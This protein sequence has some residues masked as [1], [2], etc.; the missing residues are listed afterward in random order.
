MATAA[1]ALVAS[2]LRRAR[3]LPHLG[4]AELRANAVNSSSFSS[5]TPQAPPGHDVR[6]LSSSS[7]SQALEST[8]ELDTQST[9]R[10]IG[11]SAH[12]DSGKTTLTERILF[13]SGRISQIHEV[14]GKDGVGAKMDSMELEREKG[15]TIQSAATYCSWG[16]NQINIIDT[17]GHVDFTVEVERALRVLDGAVLVL[18]SVGGVQ[19]QSITVDRQMKRYGVPRL[20][21]VNKLDR[22]GANPDKVMAQ[23]REKLR[24]NCAAVQ[25]P[26][27]LEDQHEGVVDLVNLR[28]Y[29]FEGDMGTEVAE[30]SEIPAHLAD[31][32]RERRAELVEALAEVDD[33]IGE[34]FLED[35]EPSEE[36]LKAAIRRQTIANAFVPVFMGSAYKNKGVQRLLDGVV[37]YLPAPNEVKNMALDVSREGEEKPVELCSRD[38]SLPLVAMAFKLEEGRFGQLTYLRVYQGKLKKGDFIYNTSSGK[39]IKVPRLVRMH[40]NELE[41]IAMAPAGEIVAMFGV[42]C[43]SGDTFTDGKQKVALET[44]HVA[45]P[46]M[47]LAI[48]PTSR[49]VGTQFSKALSRFQREDPTLRVHFDSETGETII[50]GMGELH[51]EIYVERMRREYKVECTTG[52]PRVNFRETVTKRAKFDYTHK[53][54]SG[55]QGQFGRVVGYIEPIPD[56]KEVEFVNNL[57]GNN[58]PPGFVPHIEKGFREACNAGSLIGHPVEGVRVVIEDG[59]AHAVDSSEMAFKLCSL[60]AFR[61]AYHECQPRILEPV[62]RCEV[63]APTEYQG[64]VIGGLN[65]KKGVINDNVQELDEAVIEAMVPLNNM[66]GYS[67]ELRSITQGKGEFSMEYAH[68]AIVSM[69]VQQELTK[70]YE[71]KR[72]GK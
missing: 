27:G 43:A 53:K 29:R 12:I 40:S 1:V 37:D 34:L 59:A 62:M 41:D 47:S 7:S 22:S 20:A 72:G 56:S 8:P 42:E 46:V 49:D 18:C 60:Y 48:T 32:V 31:V 51:L 39:K 17:P 50:S 68:H 67:T 52:K 44:M 3:F 6:F 25:V 24:L 5:W 64:D 26:I 30:T 54:Q 21:F 15:I 10:N 4:T 33:E 36:Q 16:D 55:G 61:Q 11:I 69:D 57:V 63:R 23:V 65:R 45:D 28:S 58:I 2:A 66:F 9:L 14:R 35:A 70:T 19:S 71:R 13:Y 38:P